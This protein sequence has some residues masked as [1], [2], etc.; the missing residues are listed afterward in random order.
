MACR[1]NWKQINDVQFCTKCGITRV[2]NEKVMF[3]R[4]LPNHLK[5]KKR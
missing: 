1:H 4:K 5:N 3:D 2:N